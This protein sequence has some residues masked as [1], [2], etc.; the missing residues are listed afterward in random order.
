VRASDPWSLFR[1]SDSW[2]RNPLIDDGHYTTWGA[3][4]DYDTRN[5]RYLPSTGWLLRARYEHSSS[6]DVAPVLL[7]SSV[8]PELPIGGG[9]GFDRLLI[10]LRRYSRVTPSLRV[11]GRLRAEGWIRGDRLPVQRRL[12]LGGPDVLPGYDFRAFDCSPPGFTDP[13]QPALCDRTLSAQVEVRTRL[14][15][16]LGF[17]LRDDRGR[18]TGRFIGIEE[19]D[20]VFLTDA[21]KGWLAGDG[22]GQV[23]VNRIPS[24]H[25]WKMDVGVG[26]D[27]GVIGA[28]LAKGLDDGEGVKLVVRLQRRF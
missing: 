6:S 4:V 20:L 7:P 9:Y 17:R 21:G 18:R 22:P 14:G 27:A 19:A 12:A 1:N 26:L 24:L 11:N 5:E 3:Q 16:N 10:D 2:R 28:Y 25:E 8:R 13:A 23:P 15:L